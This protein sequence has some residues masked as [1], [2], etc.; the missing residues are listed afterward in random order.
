[1]KLGV[2]ITFEGV[3]GSGKTS[4]IALLREYLK[5]RGIPF[6]LTREPGGTPIGERIRAILLDPEVGDLHMLTEMLLYAASR[7]E[8]VHSLIIP[9]LKQGKV[10]LS[11][12]YVDS[13]LAYQA[14][15]GGLSEADVRCVNR[16]A[17]GGLEPDLTILLDL[18][19]ETA[20]NERLAGKK[21]DRIE[22]RD[23]EYHR[24]V[25]RGY[26]KIAAACPDRFR[27]I[28]AS[29]GILEV[30][31]EIIALVSDFLKGRVES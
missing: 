12:R 2:F 7:A 17:T 24:S 5:G 13:S 23:I 27:V 16:I 31:D 25:Q 28:D 20:T 11:E 9:A 19:P 18:D 14:C 8:L 22:E 1:M 30:H 4:Q 6:C 3:D 10:V 21:C 15:A 26:L 29:R